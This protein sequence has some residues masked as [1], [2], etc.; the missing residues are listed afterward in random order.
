MT[1]ITEPSLKN[2]SKFWFTTL[3]GF[4]ETEFPMIVSSGANTFD[5]INTSKYTVDKFIVGSARNIASQQ[6]GFFIEKGDKIDF[7]FCTVTDSD[8]NKMFLNWHKMSL[9]PDFMQALKCYGRLPYAQVSDQF[10][11][12]EGQK[13]IVQKAQAIT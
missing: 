4:H 1:R 9:K 6:A 5:L 12:K 8:Q 7:H 10:G 11:S 13:S 2:I 3:P